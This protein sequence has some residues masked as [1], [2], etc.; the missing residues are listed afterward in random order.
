MIDDIADFSKDMVDAVDQAYFKTA[1]PVDNGMAEP[2][3]KVANLDEDALAAQ[4]SEVR[5]SS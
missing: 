5:F 1:N 4:L 3:E 2:F